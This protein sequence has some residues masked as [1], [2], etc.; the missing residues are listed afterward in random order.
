MKRSKT[1]V[2][3]ILSVCA[4]MTASA[5][6]AEKGRTKTVR[7]ER[8][9]AQPGR[10]NYYFSSAETIRTKD[11]PYRIQLISSGYQVPARHDAIRVQKNPTNT[12]S[13][14]TNSASKV[15]EVHTDSSGRV[16]YERKADG[17]DATRRYK[18][19]QGGYT[20]SRKIVVTLPDGRTIEATDAQIA[21]WGSMWTF[22]PMNPGAVLLVAQINTP[23]KLTVGEFEHLSGNMVEAQETINRDNAKI[24][25]AQAE[26]TSA[27]VNGM[28]ENFKKE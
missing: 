23:A 15:V 28:A 12:R 5:S 7:S 4:L 3:T 13:V 11:G 10:S 8:E 22:L 20:G 14:L 25:K 6:H 18:V 2:L 21:V 1:V 24:A 27:I 17:H 19:D 9:N 16:I 26:R